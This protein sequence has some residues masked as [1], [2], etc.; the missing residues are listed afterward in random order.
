MTEI[1][2]VTPRLFS[3]R[4]DAV[5]TAERL[6]GS[7][8]RVKRWR[9]REDGAPQWYVTISRGQGR[10]SLLLGEDGRLYE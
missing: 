10:R 1:V 6:G 8:G 5:V 3:A 7:H 2:Y 9:T 4:I